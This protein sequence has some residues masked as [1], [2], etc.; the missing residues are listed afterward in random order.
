MSWDRSTSYCPGGISLS[1]LQKKPPG[2]VYT[3][4]AMWVRSSIRESTGLQNGYFAV[5][6]DF[7]STMQ[8]FHCYDAVVTRFSFPKE[9]HH[10]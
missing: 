5:M 6:T 3:R 4:G 2:Y 9:T 7:L 1:E 8:S 10:V